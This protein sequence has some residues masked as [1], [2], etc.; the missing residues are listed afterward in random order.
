MQRI[1][2]LP[3]VAPVDHQVARESVEPSEDRDAAD[4]ALARGDGPPRENR[5]E[6]HHVEEALVV[7]HDDAGAKV[8]QARAI[9]AIERP[10]HHPGQPAAE[11]SSVDV[12]RLPIAR[13]EEEP[14]DSRRG[15]EE[16]PETAEEESESEEEPFP[17][18]LHAIACQLSLAPSGGI[19]SGSGMR[20][21]TARA[22]T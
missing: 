18:P 19:Q 8:L 17:D 20:R 4:L 12:E 6:G 16:K 9:L 11:D 7:R 5:A 14:D 10:S 13:G 3:R 1:S 21:N 15:A 22:W 2:G